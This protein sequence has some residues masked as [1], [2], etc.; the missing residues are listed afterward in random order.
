MIRTVDALPAFRNG[1]RDCALTGDKFFVADQSKGDYHDNFDSNTFY[2][3]MCVVE[4]IYPV[5][6]MQMQERKDNGFLE[7]DEHD[8]WD[9]G[10]QKPSRELII[11]MDNAPY[12][13][14]VQEQLSVRSKE[15]IGDLLRELKIPSIKISI[16][17]SDL[18]MNFEVPPQGKKWPIGYPS[19][20]QVREGAMTAIIA[21]KPSLVVPP[22]IPLMQEKSGGVWGSVESKGWSI[23]FNTPY[24]PSE[25]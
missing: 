12:H 17:D 15:Y 16:P 8:F 19:A 4:L 24:T 23:I 20:D 2:K 9:I 13:H 25:G 5:W 18:Q 6:C 7:A 3:W 22:Y 21:K 10:N 11:S 14:G 1:L